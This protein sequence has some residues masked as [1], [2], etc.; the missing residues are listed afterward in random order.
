MKNPVLRV[1]LALLVAIV[2]GTLVWRSRNDP[3]A[4][5]PEHS[6]NVALTKKTDVTEATAN[7]SQA[8][9]TTK[10]KPT[11]HIPTITEKRQQRADKEANKEAEIR[12]KLSE[13]S[14]KTGLT[15]NEL[16]LQAES[17]YYPERWR[18]RFAARME[19]IRESDMAAGG[20]YAQMWKREAELELLTKQL[21]NGMSF[22]A[23]T[24]LLGKPFRAETR[25]TT[26]HFSNLLP[27]PL[28]LLELPRENLSLTYS[29]HPKKAH[30]SM[31]DDMRDWRILTVFLD[32]QRQL[33]GWKYQPPPGMW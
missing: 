3:T 6:S 23:I 1:T 4:T 28:D 25:I 21:T 16:W 33:S 22:S 11:H 7:S 17:Y 13:L 24:N 9:V 19:A 15:T 31:G 30:H 29:P 32:D 8:S 14:A 27:V 18:L 20:D 5:S 12:A 10:S 26:N 2:L